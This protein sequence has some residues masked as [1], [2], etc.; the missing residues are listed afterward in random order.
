MLKRYISVQNGLDSDTR[1]GL[2]VRNL[3]FTRVYYNN[4]NSLPFFFHPN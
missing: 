3:V 2:L 1:E 4:G